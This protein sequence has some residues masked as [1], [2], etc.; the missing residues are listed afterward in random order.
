MSETKAPPPLDDTPAYNFAQ[1][2]VEIEPGR[3][4][5]LYCTGHGSPAIILESGLGGGG[6]RLGPD[7]RKPCHED[8]DLRL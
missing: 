1:Q 2:L 8:A 6:V 4:I 5:N 3:K 7:S